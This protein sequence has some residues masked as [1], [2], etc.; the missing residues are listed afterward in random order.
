MCWFF[1]FMRAVKC[2]FCCMPQV[3][4]DFVF[5]GGLLHISVKNIGNDSAYRISVVFEPGF[6]GIEGSTDISNL[7]VFNHL[8][9]LPPQKEVVTFLDRS[10]SYFRRNEPTRITT[11]ITFHNSRGKEFC[12]V[13]THNLEIYRDIGFVERRICMHSD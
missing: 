13:I 7:A 8:E 11:K 4:V 1:N 6:R 3:I 12:N 10:A 9:F 2:A 5:D